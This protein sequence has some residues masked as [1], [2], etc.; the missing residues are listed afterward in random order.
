MKTKKRN[1]STFEL[2]IED[3]AFI[4]SLSEKTLIP[5]VR[6]IRMALRLLKEKQDKLTIN[7]DTIN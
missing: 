3:R 6:L 4:E 1:F 7:C 5:K 2:S